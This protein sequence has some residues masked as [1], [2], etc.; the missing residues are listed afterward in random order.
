[1]NNRIIGNKGELL[2]KELLVAKGYEILDR[3]FNCPYGEA[4][5]IARTDDTVI[6]AEVKFRR[7]TKFGYPR[8][9]VTIRKQDKLRLTAEYY[10]QEKNL[11]NVDIRF[12]VI[13]I[14]QTG[15]KITTEHLEN[16]F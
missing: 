4:D 8:E 11:I 16:A 14:L 7:S 2:A 13:E 10:L 9:A 6:F 1:M 5:I 15:N 3:N 12:D